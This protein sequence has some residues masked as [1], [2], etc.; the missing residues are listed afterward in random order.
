MKPSLSLAAAMG[1]LAL[2]ASSINAAVIS[3][4]PTNLVTSFISLGEWN[5]QPI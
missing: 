3:I 1:T 2:S 4:D 5:R